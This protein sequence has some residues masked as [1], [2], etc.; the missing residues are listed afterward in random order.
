[1]LVATLAACG[2]TSS[3]LDRETAM[4]HSMDAVLHVAAD[5]ASPL[6][7][8]RLQLRSAEPYGRGGWRVRVADRTTHATI[9]V[10]DVPRPDAI[11]GTGESL[12]LVTCAG[13]AQVEPAPATTSGGA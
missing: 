2:S 9:C 3:E 6:Y 13:P 8:H 4:Q 10:T 11:V 5:P 1:M 7:H 12:R